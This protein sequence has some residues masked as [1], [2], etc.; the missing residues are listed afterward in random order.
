[1]GSPEAPPK[2]GSFTRL[3]GLQ[4]WRS[5]CA[6]MGTGTPMQASVS[7]PAEAF[8]TWNRMSTAAVSVPQLSVTTT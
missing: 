4:R 6:P 7:G 2:A 1:M 3:A 5:S 8:G